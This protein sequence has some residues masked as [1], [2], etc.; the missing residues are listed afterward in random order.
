MFC[1]ISSVL[2]HQP[3]K[4]VFEFMSLPVNDHTWQSET[5]ASALINRADMA[6]GTY[7][8]S[9]GNLMGNRNLST[10]EVT[11][12][13][14]NYTYGYR[15]LSGPMH[16]QSSYRFAAEQGGTRITITTQIHAVKP[17]RLQ[18]GLLKKQLKKQLKE[19][20]TFLKNNL[21]TA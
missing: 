5:F 11:E 4:Q 12:Y 14:P 6:V 20:L 8:R 9:I 1:V 10:F 15:S 13:E 18:A 21:E 7:F 16:S 2:I 17:A 3:I 19:N